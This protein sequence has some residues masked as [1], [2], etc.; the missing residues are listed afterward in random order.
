MPAPLTDHGLRT[1]CLLLLKCFYCKQ[2][3]D[4]LD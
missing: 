3:D 4:K 1:L 2:M